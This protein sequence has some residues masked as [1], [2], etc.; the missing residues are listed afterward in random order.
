MFHVASWRFKIVYAIVMLMAIVPIGISNTGWVA[1]TLGRGSSPFAA[2]P[3]VGPV[4][5]FVLGAYRI[6]L[7]AREPKTLDSYRTTGASQFFRTVGIAALYVGAIFAVINAVAIP[8]MAVLISRPSES[9][10]EFYLVGVLL[11]LVPAFGPIGL[12][13]FEFSRLLAFEAEARF[14]DS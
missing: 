13:L 5:F 8:V 3:L 2:L 4:V 10:V 9:G 6:W 7:V 1:A 11:A 12:A 14:N